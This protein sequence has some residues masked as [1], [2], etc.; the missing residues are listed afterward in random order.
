MP[1]QF[2]MKKRLA[3]L[4]EEVERK[5]ADFEAGRIADKNYYRKF[6]DRA[7][8]ESE[9]LRADLKSFEQAARFSGGT[10]AGGMGVTQS[11]ASPGPG[12][13]LR[14]VSAYDMTPDQLEQL[15]M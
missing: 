8:V 11:S 15:V 2:A 7:R 1:N 9:E 12:E 5:T 14:P 4:R 3:E 6:I 10:E 13:L